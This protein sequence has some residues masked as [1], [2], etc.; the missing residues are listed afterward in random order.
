MAA[1]LIRAW[2]LTA[3]SDGLF[4]S[5][6]NAV[7][8][9]ST[10]AR[11]WQGV[12]ATA[13]G[14]DRFTSESTQVIAG[15]AVHVTVALV[16][17]TVFLVAYDNSASLRHLT[18]SRFGVL[19]VAAIYGPLIWV[20]MAMV[21]IRV[22]TGRTP[23]ITYRWWIQFFGHIIFVALPIVAMTVRPRRKAGQDMP[24]RM[25]TACQTPNSVH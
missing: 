8:Y 25:H 1:R 10:V 16:W 4:S 21:V 12:A 17:T 23:P 24:E 22:A 14:A 5:V 7:F 11:L 13:F 19:K 18:A 2:L 6:L 3:V 20:V 9:G 15:L